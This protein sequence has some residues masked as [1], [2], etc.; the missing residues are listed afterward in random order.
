M[1]QP[2][3]CR[4]LFPSSATRTDILSEIPDLSCMSSWIN[5]HG[6]S[7]YADS[8]TSVLFR[9]PFEYVLK[10][11]CPYYQKTILFKKVLMPASFLLNSRSENVFSYLDHPNPA[12]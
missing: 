12:D 1:T 4:H 5:K 9:F 11:I 10:A 3:I 2:E 6:K 7:G 8:Y